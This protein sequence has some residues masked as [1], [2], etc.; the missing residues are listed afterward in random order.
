[1][2]YN[3]IFKVRS[4]A[5]FSLHIIGLSLIISL[6]SW[7]AVQFQLI[8]CLPSNR[9]VVDG[10]GIWVCVANSPSEHARGLS[11][12]RYIPRNWGMLFVFKDYSHHRFWMKDMNYPIDIVWLNDS[13]QPVE[14]A[15]NA[16]PESYPGLFVPK[17]ANRFV[18]ETNV[19]RI[20]GEYPAVKIEN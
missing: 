20:I 3:T 16:T 7:G 18:L 9:I 8:P 4:L 11:E 19:G 14:V 17:Y 5:Q 15:R 13:L 12:T 2:H 1:M 6:F 10:V